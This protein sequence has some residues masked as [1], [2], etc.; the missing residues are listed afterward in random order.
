VARAKV[1]VIIREGEGQHRL[2]SPRFSSVS[3]A[4]EEL[5]KVRE[6]M[7]RGGSGAADITGFDWLSVVPSQIV[8]APVEEV[9]R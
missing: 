4:Q 1:I 8:S 2:E 6:A 3:A 5:E 7:R 9:D